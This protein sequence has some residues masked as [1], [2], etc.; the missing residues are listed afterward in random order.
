MGVGDLDPG[1]LDR[2]LIARANELQSMSSCQLQSQE[3]QLMM[4]KVR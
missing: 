4:Q 3:G 2:L 1:D